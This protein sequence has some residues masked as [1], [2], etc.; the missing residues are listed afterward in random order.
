MQLK[1]G[2]ENAFTVSMNLANNIGLL[3]SVSAGELFFLRNLWCANGSL[4]L[5]ALL[6]FPPRRTGVFLSLS[7]FLEAGRAAC[8]NFQAIWGISHWPRLITSVLCR[9]YLLFSCA[10]FHHVL[11]HFAVKRKALNSDCSCRKSL[12]WWQVGLTMIRPGPTLP[13]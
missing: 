8:S 10:S 1:P 13:L 4:S 3:W 12:C 11:D 6:L 7:G 5:L 2:F 9:F